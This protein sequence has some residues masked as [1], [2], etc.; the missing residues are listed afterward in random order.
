MKN[1]SYGSTCRTPNLLGKCTKDLGY[2]RAREL[3]AFVGTFKCDGTIRAE[4][5]GR[6]W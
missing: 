1:T 3:L 6:S 4:W 5:Y 2:E